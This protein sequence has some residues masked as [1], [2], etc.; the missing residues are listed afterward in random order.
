MDAIL[1]MARGL[2]RMLAA[3]PRTTTLRALED[4]ILKDAEA[5]R[6]LEDYEKSRLTLDYKERNMQPIGPEEK[7]AHA[8]VTRRVHAVPALLELARAQADYAQMM[9]EVN[10][11]IHDVLRPPAD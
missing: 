8:E 10:R 1:D 9:D 2:A 5:R 6:L 4:Q 11:A 7:R 3:D